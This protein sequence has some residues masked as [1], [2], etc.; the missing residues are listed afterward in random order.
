MFVV[1]SQA[2]NHVK[3]QGHCTWYKQCGDK[4]NCE[5]SGPAKELTDARALKTLKRLCPQFVSD[6]GK[7]KNVTYEIPFMTGF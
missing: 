2:D 6:N 1:D 5:Y 4:Y 3:D 7:T